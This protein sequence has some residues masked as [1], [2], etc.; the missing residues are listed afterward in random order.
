MISG[1]FL[2]VWLCLLGWTGLQVTGCKSR[3]PATDYGYLLQDDGTSDQDSDTKPPEGEGGSEV[4]A[5]PESDLPIEEEVIS[6][7][8]QKVLGEAKS[9]LGVPYRYGGINHNGID[10]SGLARN[11]YKAIGVELPRSSKEQASYG[12]PVKRDRLRPGDLV[13]FSAKNDGRIDHVGIVSQVK[14][15][16]VSFIHA[17]T[18]SGVRFDRLD[19]GYWKN[20]FQSARRPGLH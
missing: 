16:E 20:L 15:E 14:G 3:K 9:Y 13:F 2:I 19:V 6:E 17:T 10:C 12:T 8:I 18:R 1:R 5:E 7:P 11:S 4:V